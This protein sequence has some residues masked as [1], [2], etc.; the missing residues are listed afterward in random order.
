[1]FVPDKKLLSAVVLSA[2]LLAAAP[3]C[4]EEARPALHPEGQVI[5]FGVSGHDTVIDYVYDDDGN[6]IGHLPGSGWGGHAKLIDGDTLFLSEED[7]LSVVRTRDLKTIASEGPQT[8]IRLVSPGFYI[9]LETQNGVLTLYNSEGEPLGAVSVT[10]GA[11]SGGFDGGFQSFSRFLE[12]PDARLLIMSIDGKKNWIW[13]DKETGS[14]RLET[15]PELLKMLDDDAMTV[16]AFGDYLAFFPEFRSGGLTGTIMTRDGLLLMD[17][18]DGNVKEKRPEAFLDS[19]LNYDFRNE[20][21]RL[22]AV[23]RRNGSGYDLYVP[24]RLELI[25]TMAEPPDVNDGSC[26]G[27]FPGIASEELGGNVRAGLVFDVDS[28][29]YCPYAVTG[30]EVLI[31]KDGALMS[32]PV[33]GKPYAVSSAYYV[34]EGDD[35]TTVYKTSDRSVFA[36]L[37]SSPHTC[38]SLGDGGIAIDDAPADPE[39][40]WDRTRTIYNN[41]GQPVYQSRNPYLRAFYN[42][43]WFEHR[44]IYMGIIDSS[45]RWLLK[46]TMARE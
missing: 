41:E 20:E 37:D 40:W 32:F 44:G 35:T 21:K 10:G 30:N 39:K 26:R 22:T 13:F 15:N 4:A 1:M 7:G 11:E 23:W 14:A 8:Q 9:I 43:T 5:L 38:I 6:R 28:L 46:D 17:N 42:G 34:A 45:G 29:N 31:L 19:F 12:F 3:V 24:E 36:S 33:E 25:G 2:A 16:Y 18:L 27:F